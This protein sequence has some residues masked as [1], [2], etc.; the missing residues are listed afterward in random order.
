MDVSIK[1]NPSLE[2]QPAPRM[3]LE[4]TIE[5]KPESERVLIQPLQETSISL[6]KLG[7]QSDKTLLHHDGQPPPANGEPAAGRNEHKP[8]GSHSKDKDEQLSMNE[9]V[10]SDEDTDGWVGNGDQ[11]ADVDLV[12]RW[13]RAYRLSIGEAGMMLNMQPEIVNRAVAVHAQSTSGCDPNAGEAGVRRSTRPA[14]KNWVKLGP[15]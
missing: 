4:P 13:A 5:S 6:G 11:L 1:A 9:P 14:I 10:D 2:Y 12:L 7:S 15:L 8:P 3:A